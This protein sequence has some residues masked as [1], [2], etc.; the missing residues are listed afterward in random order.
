[1][2]Q[3][4]HQHFSKL[5]NQQSSF[6]IWAMPAVSPYLEFGEPSS[7]EELEVALS[8]LKRRK[9]WYSSRVVVRWSCAT[10]VVWSEM[11]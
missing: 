8:W 11:V 4:W 5:L 1:M 10:G 6:D 9:D 2:L 7:M 3:Q